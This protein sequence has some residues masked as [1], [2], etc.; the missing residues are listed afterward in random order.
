MI[1]H[2]LEGEQ[3]RPLRL[4][5]TVSGAEVVAAA[6]VGTI[7]K[8]LSY[9]NKFKVNMNLQRE[10]ASRESKAFQMTQ[11]QK[12]DNPLSDVA[13]AMLHSAR[14]RFKE[15][16][17]GLS[18][19]IEQHLSLRLDSLRLAVFPRTM[20]DLEMA[21]F[22]GSAV[23]ARLDRKTGS[24]GL[25]ARRILHLS[26]ASMTISKYSQLNHN[27]SATASPSDG[28]SWLTLLLRGASEAIIVGL[29]SMNMAMSSEESLGTVAKELLYDFNSKFVR[30]EGM[31][32]FEDIF[33]TLNMSLYSWLTVLRKNLTREMGQV[34]AASDWRS[35]MTHLPSVIGS[36]KKALE[37]LHLHLPELREDS[38]DALFSSRSSAWPLT[39]PLPSAAGV[40]SP[41][42]SAEPQALSPVSD[43][44][45]EIP[46]PGNSPVARP[47]G[48][49]SSVPLPSSKKSIGIVY[50]PG[51]RHI[52]RLNM[53]QLGE[54]TPDVMHPFFMKKA[55]FN[56][57]DSLPQYVHEYATI[58]IEQIM[59]VLLRLYSK[60][61]R[62]DRDTDDGDE[63]SPPLSLV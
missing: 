31:R 11:S 26:F 23:H 52:E 35:G 32:N 61:L 4:S 51:E 62:A 28:N 10:G 27:L 46:D 24:D 8:L 25:L 3:E 63:K 1:S 14:D 5:F 16:E 42:I 44:G 59:Q 55:G 57:E 6:T 56:L 41:S 40:Q 43:P 36:R 45:F 38:T 50:R 54:A 60:Q 20:G 21:Q 22:I 18:Y 53:R 48:V 12:P 58:P 15:A 2:D 9:V 47:I 29:P 37:P 33:I 13:N 7:P 17:V 19:I 34:Q 30:R 49:S 39:T